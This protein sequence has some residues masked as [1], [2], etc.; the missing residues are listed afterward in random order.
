MPK[1]GRGLPIAEGWQQ[2]QPQKAGWSRINA[3]QDKGVANAA[4]E[5]GGWCVAG[6][7]WNGKEGRT[8]AGR[9][10]GRKARQN[11]QQAPAA[12]ARPNQQ[13]VAW[14][15]LGI[16]VGTSWVMDDDTYLMIMTM[17]QA[18]AGL[19][20][21]VPTAG[22]ATSTA[23]TLSPSL[24]LSLSLSNCSNTG[25]CASKQAGMQCSAGTHAQ[26]GH[27]RSMVLS[28]RCRPAA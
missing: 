13:Q 2:E 4:A 10:L 1:P 17:M 21:I 11:K 12:E 8:A 3:G 19:V 25:K 14:L 16:R 5:A 18:K 26:R 22:T 9:L 7:M 23:Q 27:A 6:P 24:S 28:P 15:A 20:G